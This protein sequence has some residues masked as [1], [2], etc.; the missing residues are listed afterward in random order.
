MSR[1]R[2]IAT[3][4]T[5]TLPENVQ[6]TISERY[7][8]P[9]DIVRNVAHLIATQAGGGL[10]NVPELRS[11]A[12]LM[13]EWVIKNIAI[14]QIR[15]N[16]DYARVWKGWH[17][18]NYRKQS[19]VKEIVKNLF[20][21]KNIKNILDFTL[22]DIEDVLDEFESPTKTLAENTLT[23]TLPAGAELFFQSDGWSVLKVTDAEAACVLGKGT[24]WCT[25]SRN[26]EDGYPETAAQYLESG[27][28]YIFYK[29]NKKYAQLH[30]PNDDYGFQLMDLRDRTIIPDES[31]REVLWKSGLF[32]EMFNN[33]PFSGKNR[34]QAL[35]GNTPF[36]EAEHLIAAFAESALHYAELFPQSLSP[37]VERGIAKSS[38]TAYR[39][40]SQVL[41][42]RFPLG[43]PAISGDRD[44]SLNYAKFVLHDRFPLGEPAIQ[45]AWDT[46]E[47]Y[48]KFLRSIGKENE[49]QWKHS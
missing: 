25:S 22:H 15:P 38:A 42:G 40:A 10:S 9:L 14:G 1:L 32:K 18:L 43:E 23:R 34:I 48:R 29:G 21:G 24:K 2:R 13:V 17:F 8:I 37:V 28:L 35:V 36:P 49:V 7:K 6:K 27:P 45:F 31:L 44:L 47:K 26:G 5:A 4:V 3:L 11:Y 30:I 33:T 20:P 16:E 46:E 39:Y 41:K 12:D 19:K